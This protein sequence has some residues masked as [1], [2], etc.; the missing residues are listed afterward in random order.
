MGQIITQKYSIY[1]KVFFF[2]LSSTDV[3]MKLIAQSIL[4]CCVLTTVAHSTELDANPELKKRYVPQSNS[5]KWILNF[6]GKKNQN[7]VVHI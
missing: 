7:R 3:K 1:I 6:G 4:Y 2:L 5:P